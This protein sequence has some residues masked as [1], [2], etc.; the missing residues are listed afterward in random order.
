MQNNSKPAPK[1]NGWPR[2]IGGRIAAVIYQ[3]WP[4]KIYDGKHVFFLAIL[5][6]SDKFSLQF[7][8]K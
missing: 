3:K 6:F 7:S 5:S 2:K 8:P 4:K 1:T